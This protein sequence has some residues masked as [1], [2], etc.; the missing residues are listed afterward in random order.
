MSEQTK[1]IKELINRSYKKYAYNWTAERSMGNYDD[2]FDDGFTCGE[3]QLAY[4][5]GM[6][7]GMDLEEPEEPDED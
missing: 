7:L 2:C 3:T 4:E 1:E 5:I 6:I